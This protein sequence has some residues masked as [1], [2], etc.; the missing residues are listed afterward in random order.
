[1]NKK[2]IRPGQIWKVNKSN[3]N[4][5]MANTYL[6]IL[7]KRSTKLIRDE[8]VWNIGNFWKLGGDIGGAREAQ[9]LTKEIH[10]LEYVGELQELIELKEKQ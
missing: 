8:D 5:L 1:M 4:S 2:E 3:L 7:S 6:I 9:L 10:A